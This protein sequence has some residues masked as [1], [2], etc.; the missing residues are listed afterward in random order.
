M[1]TELKDSCT[2]SAKDKFF[3]FLVRIKSGVT[4]EFLSAVTNVS[5]TSISRILS[6]VI[7]FVYIKLKA[8]D[9]W[10]SKS[11][12]L[13]YMP[14]AFLRTYPN[15]RLI[16]DCT[17]IAIHKTSNPRIQQLTFSHYKNKNTLKALIGITPS[18]AICYISDLWCGGISDKKL[19]LESGL[20]NHLSND[21]ILAD[22]GF[23]IHKE[24]QKKN[25]NL[26]TP[27]FLKNLIQFSVEE[28]EE[29]KKVSNLRVHVERAISRIKKYRYFKGTVPSQC[30]HEVN[31]IFF[32][33]AFFTNFS[34]PLIKIV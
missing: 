33:C 24:L 17:E 28:R 25:C 9:I 21:T 26:V 31:R 14:E 6:S 5:K 10:P 13:E 3:I 15:C 29:N 30:F 20:L 32:I 16:L 11:Q 27:H 8:I 1:L 19:F 34:E 22:R 12:V 23:L 18:G 2:V 7:D 4:I